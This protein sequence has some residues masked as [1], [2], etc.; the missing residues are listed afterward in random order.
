MQTVHHILRLSSA[1]IISTLAPSQRVHDKDHSDS[2]LDLVF[3]TVPSHWRRFGVNTQVHIQT[4]SEQVIGLFYDLSRQFIHSPIIIATTEWPRRITRSAFPV[5][6][7]SIYSGTIARSIVQ[8]GHPTNRRDPRAPRSSFNA[9]RWTKSRGK[10]RQWQ[11]PIP[12][13]S[14]GKHYT[15]R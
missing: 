10:W 6:S 2:D 1:Q 12:R 14:S 8:R 13:S 11:R 7:C 3:W 5:L 15:E 9:P 4:S